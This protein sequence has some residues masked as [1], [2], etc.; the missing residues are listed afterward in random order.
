MADGFLHLSIKEGIAMK[1]YIIRLAE[2]GKMQLPE[3]VQKALHGAQK[4]HISRVGGH[5]ELEFPDGTPI[6]V[7]DD[8]QVSA[9]TSCHPHG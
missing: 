6:L 4:I 8:A 7:T 2:D 5:F 1:K 3:S 9:S